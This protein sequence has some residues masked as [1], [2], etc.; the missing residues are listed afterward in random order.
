MEF[1]LRQLIISKCQARGISIEH[2]AQVSDCT[3]TELKGFEQGLFIL[4]IDKLAKLIEVLSI[5]DDELIS[6]LGD[7]SANRFFQKLLTSVDRKA[8]S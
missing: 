2:L 8:G 6:T 5:S 7:E 4:T 3:I 1:E